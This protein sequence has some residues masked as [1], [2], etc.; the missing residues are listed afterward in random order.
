MNY[1]EEN[2]Y[3]E[4]EFFPAF[5]NTNFLT[6]YLRDDRGVQGLSAEQEAASDDNSFI[7]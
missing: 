1:T 6:K 2:Y 7:R 5:L 4:M 3:L